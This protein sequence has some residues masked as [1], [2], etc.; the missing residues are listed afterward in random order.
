MWTYI[1]TRVLPGVYAILYK[2]EETGE[3]VVSSDGVDYPFAF[4]SEAVAFRED[5]RKS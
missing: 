5:L 2:N 4:R 1:N 3:Y